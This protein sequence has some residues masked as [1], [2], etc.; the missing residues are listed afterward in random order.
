MRD[1]RYNYTY[2]SCYIVTMCLIGI[3]R[4]G[5]IIFSIALILCYCFRV[6]DVQSLLTCKRFKRSLRNV[7]VVTGVTRT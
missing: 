1:K 4:G 7:L 2:I 5:A 3:Y 6:E